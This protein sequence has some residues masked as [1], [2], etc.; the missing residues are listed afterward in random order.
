MRY[1]STGAKN[2]NNDRSF[3]SSTKKVFNKNEF[4]DKGED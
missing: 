4:F 2:K 1:N 3:K